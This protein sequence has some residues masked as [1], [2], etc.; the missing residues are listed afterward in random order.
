MKN[1]IY[2]VIILYITS[3]LAVAGTSDT[4]MIPVCIAV[5]CD[6]ETIPLLNYQIRTE[7]KPET[8]LNSEMAGKRMVA[9]YSMWRTGKADEKG[10]IHVKIERGFNY[11]I[12]ARPRVDCPYYGKL[13]LKKSALS[14]LSNTNVLTMTVSKCVDVKGVV[15][16]KRGEP[17]A[18]M[19]V[20]LEYRKG[21]HRSFDWDMTNENGEFSIA[22]I[23]G[24]EAFEI[25]GKKGDLNIVRQKIE[26]GLNLR[27][28]AEL[29]SSE[30]L[31][32]VS[33]NEIEKELSMEL[34][35]EYEKE[36]PK[37]KRGSARNA[38]E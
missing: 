8:Q 19:R 28:I 20:D 35:D 2:S 31:E 29:R 17:V 21:V 36:F 33:D 5:K 6:G 18:S 34:L 3:Y 14:T 37:N 16:D 11:T 38:E 15:V 22:M 12:E 10:L 4:N 30:N 7:K 32:D 26:P 25:Y 23:E 1:L 27:V 9:K 13:E 24:G